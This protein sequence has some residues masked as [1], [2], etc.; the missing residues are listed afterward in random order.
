MFGSSCPFAIVQPSMKSGRDANA[1][2]LICV[3]AALLATEKSL[4]PHAASRMLWRVAV[5]AAVHHCDDRDGAEH[6]AVADKSRTEKSTS[7]AAVEN[8]SVPKSTRSARGSTNA[9]GKL[10]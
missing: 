1:V 9:A 4:G 7:V 10:G 8:N 5:R 6:A 3:G 2:A